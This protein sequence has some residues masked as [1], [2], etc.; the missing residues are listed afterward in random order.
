MEMLIPGVG[1][2]TLGP[3]VQNNAAE[4]LLDFIRAV[5]ASSPGLSTTSKVLPSLIRALR[6]LLLATADLVWGHIWGVGAET[7]VV[8]TGLVGLDLKGGGRPD[9]LVSHEGYTDGSYRP[10]EGGGHEH[11]RYDA[12]LAANATLG[13]VFRVCHDEITAKYV[14]S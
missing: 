9:G 14:S 4:R 3:L 11:W 1:P 8:S 13:L 12:A 2:R 5:L 10:V 7:E 6:N